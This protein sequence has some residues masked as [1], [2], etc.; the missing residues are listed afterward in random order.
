M[1]SAFKEMPDKQPTLAINTD[2]WLTGGTV[3]FLI[4]GT[5]KIH[6]L[7]PKCAVFAVF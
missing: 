5:P 4:L 2:L 3:L 1:F 7:N 6:I